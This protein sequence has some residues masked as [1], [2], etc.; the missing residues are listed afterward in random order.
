MKK[1]Q[2]TTTIDDT[3]LAV[4]ERQP[5]SWR[6]L[7]VRRGDRPTVLNAR[8]FAATD[9]AGLASWLESQRCGDLRVVLPSSATIIRSVAVPAAA[10]M[11]M[12]AALR[13][14][15]EGMFLGSMP[16]ARIGLGVIDGAS[17]AERQGII[18]AWPESQ[19]GVGVGGRLESMA[20]YVPEPAAMLALASGNRPVISADRRDGSIAVALRGPSGLVLRATRETPGDD[21]EGDTAWNEGLRRALVETALNAGMEPG[22]IAAFIGETERSVS[23]DGDRVFLFDAGLR[24]H[25]EAR[26]SVQVAA[27]DGDG[28]WWSTWAI[29]LGAA[30]VACGPLAELSKMRRFEERNA[31][32]GVERFIERYS[33]P[34]RA[35]RVGLVAFTLVGVA[36]IASAWLRGKVLEFKMPEASHAF[37]RSQRDIEQ[38]IA[39]YTELSKRTLPVAKILGDLACCTPDGIEIESI[40]LSPT[41]GV[42][43]RGVAKAQGERS[44]AE[45]VNSMATLMDSSGV[46]DKTH[47]RWNTPDGRG[48]FKFDLDALIVRPTL[49]ADFPEER[50]WAVKTLAQRKYGSIADE[51]DGG[52]QPSAGSTAAATDTGKPDATKPAVADAGKP[53]DGAGDGAPPETAIAQGNRP[54]ATDVGA[55]GSTGAADG[56]TT[57]LPSRGIGRRDPASAPGAGTTPPA[58][59]AATKPATAGSGAGAGGGPAATAAANTAVPDAFTDEQLAAMSKEEARTLLSEISKARRRNELDADTRKRLADDFQRILEHLK[60]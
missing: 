29:P 11:Q 27:A 49:D 60:K 39:L 54:P 40:Q 51:A 43:L 13:L 57:S 32:T 52:A 41:Q 4:A 47:W 26:L 18:M 23:R 45:I 2:P 1:A 38:R 48:I 25:L 42:T 50:D 56:S 33:Q 19:I 53:A 59:D 15:A 28:D 44:A 3:L 55:A 35:L 58:T 37:E 8:E 21:V 16:I 14:Q 22:A 9:E 24:S 10:P 17:D 31:P 46:F 5:D 34:S 30:V 6:V 36:P 7:L 12:L 20:R